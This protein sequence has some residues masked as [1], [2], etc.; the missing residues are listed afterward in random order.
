[1]HR[2]TQKGRGDTD[3]KVFSVLCFSEAPAKGELLWENIVDHTSPLDLRLET[4]FE[5]VR[6][7]IALASLFY[8]SVV[9][10]WKQLVFA[11]PRRWT[12][13]C[14]HSVSNSSWE[15]VFQQ[16]DRVHVWYEIILNS[17]LISI[18]L[19]PVYPLCIR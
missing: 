2:R 4:D 3:D 18:R 19:Q 5:R 12:R 16:C 10:T 15:A 6:C 17:V 9:I 11:F 8:D 13:I 14:S 7:T 1:M